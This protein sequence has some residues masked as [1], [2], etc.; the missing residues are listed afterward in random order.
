M[1]KRRFHPFNRSNCTFVKNG[2]SEA[3][4]PSSLWLGLLFSV[5]GTL[6]IAT[7]KNPRRSLLTKTVYE[8]WTFL[9]GLGLAKGDTLVFINGIIFLIAGVAM[10]VRLA[11]LLI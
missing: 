6:L 1:D 8:L 9:P 11:T 7:L 4:S 3:L 10:L 5:M 2:R